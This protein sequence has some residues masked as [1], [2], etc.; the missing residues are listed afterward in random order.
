MLP[1]SLSKKWSQLL[2]RTTKLGSLRQI[3]WDEREALNNAE[4]LENCDK[5]NSQLWNCCPIQLY[6]YLEP[7]CKLR[8]FPISVTTQTAECIWACFRRKIFLFWTCFHHRHFVWFEI[9]F[10][11]GNASLIGKF[12]KNQDLESR[13]RA[14]VHASKTSRC[15]YGRP[16]TTAHS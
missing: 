1:S 7:C 3:L 5:L 11:F 2:R 9:C 14:N 10:I 16:H 6:N 15:A 13:R 12:F 4:S 8:Q